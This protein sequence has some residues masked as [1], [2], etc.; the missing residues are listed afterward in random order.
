[1]ISGAPGCCCDDMHTHA[2]ASTHTRILALPAH[3]RT[4]AILTMLVT[5]G[6]APFCSSRRT[7]FRWPMKAA[8]CIGVRPDCGTNDSSFTALHRRAA[9]SP[10]DYRVRTEGAGGGAESRRGRLVT[11]ALSTSVTAWMEAPYFTSSSMTL[12]RFFLQAMCSGVKP[13]CARDNRV[14]GRHAGTTLARSMLHTTGTDVTSSC[15]TLPMWLVLELGM[16]GDSVYLQHWAC[17][18]EWVCMLPCS[19]G[20]GPPLQRW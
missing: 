8:T 5:S 16:G 19:C 2:H 3:P 9:A 1:M 11:G 20:H 14:S 7:I 17:L 4:P 15:V 10:R 6:E 12:M 13:F 18:R